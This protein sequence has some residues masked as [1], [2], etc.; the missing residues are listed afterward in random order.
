MGRE[1]KSPIDS[2]NCLLLL[3]H[4]D[5]IDEPYGTNVARTLNKQYQNIQGYIDTMV[6]SNWLDRPEGRKAELELKPKM[7][8][9][10]HPAYLSV[11]DQLKDEVAE[12]D[13]EELEEEVLEIFSTGFIERMRR[14]VQLSPF[15]VKDKSDRYAFYEIGDTDSYPEDA[16]EIFTNST[17]GQ[18]VKEIKDMFYNYRVSKYILEGSNSLSGSET[19]LKNS[20]EYITIKQYKELVES[21]LF[22]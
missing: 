6:R 3:Y 16:E 10:A 14:K 20:D 12:E 15:K 1:I 18:I 8:V 2:K 7:I 5:R 19:A 22:N 4:I 13:Q 21:D 9:S 17:P 11:L